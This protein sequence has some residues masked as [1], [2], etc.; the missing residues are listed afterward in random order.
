MIQKIFNENATN[1]G[2]KV[3]QLKD[4]FKKV[5]QRNKNGIIKNVITNSAEYG[6][7]PQRNFFDKNIAVDGNTNNYYII[8]KGNFVYNPRRSKTAPY[9]P[10]NYYKLE[11]LGIISPLYICL[12]LTENIDP[13]YLSWYFKSNAW[14]RYIYDNGSQGVRHD[15]VSMT[16][17]LLMGIPVLIPEKAIQKRIAKMLDLLENNIIE[18]ENL[19]KALHIAKSTLLKEIFI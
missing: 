17:D 16:D 4:I 15:R 13:N 1:T 3:L 18:S 19:L 12:A 7:V 5:T 10:F 14:H 2:W 11:E 8:E 9:G 6:L